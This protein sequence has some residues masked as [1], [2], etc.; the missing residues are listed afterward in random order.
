M[1]IVKSIMGL[2]VH[3]MGQ[4]NNVKKKG[5]ACTISLYILDSETAQY[6]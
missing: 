5:I 3:N 4:C 6:N 1:Y 2:F